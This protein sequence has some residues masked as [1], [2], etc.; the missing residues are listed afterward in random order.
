MPYILTKHGE[1]QLGDPG[2]DNTVRVLYVANLDD[3]AD[4]GATLPVAG[5]HTGLP[6]GTYVSEPSELYS[7]Y[8]MP[9]KAE[10][11]LRLEGVEQQPR[12]KVTFRSRSADSFTAAGIKTQVIQPGGPE[13]NDVSASYRLVS[14]MLGELSTDLSEEVPAKMRRE[15]RPKLAAALRA[16]A[17]ALEPVVSDE[18]A[19]GAA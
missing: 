17:D 8:E 12:L 5:S 10:V 11:P 13:V 9:V 7:K 4:S 19:G 2:F 3:K 1:L 16:L 14:G 18:K 6:G 15:E